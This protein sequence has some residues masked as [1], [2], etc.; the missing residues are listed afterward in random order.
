LFAAMAVI[1]GIPYLLIKIAVEG[2]SVPVLVFART[3]IGAAVLLPLALSRSAWATVFRHWRPVLGFAFFEI[4]AAWLLLSDAERHLSSSLTGLL[5]AAAPIIAAVLA[6]LTGSEREFGVKRIAGL[7]V[8]LVGVAV[9]AGPELTGG[10]AWPV[11]EI[12]LVSTCYAIAPLIAARY[13]GDVPSLPLTAACLGV[14]ALVYAGPAA[15]T[16]PDQLPDTRVLLA[17]RPCAGV[18]LRQPGG[19]ARRGRDRLAR[20]ADAV[21]RRGTGLD[22]RGFGAGH[23]APHLTALIRR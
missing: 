11:T 20:T 21:E 19:G 23:Q 7:V 13:L 22:P 2:V 1:W 5:I 3:A 16:W 12:L 14:A 9:L 10:S 6:R 15:A 18:H 4:I 8:G 17:C